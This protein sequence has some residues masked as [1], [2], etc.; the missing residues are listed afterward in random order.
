MGSRLVHNRP[1]PACCEN[2][3][4]GSVTSQ[5]RDGPERD[6]CGQVAHWSRGCAKPKISFFFAPEFV[7]HKIL[8][9]YS[10]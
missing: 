4:Y 3:R 10:S 9:L 7:D 8:A 5:Q 6:D 1:G 2:A